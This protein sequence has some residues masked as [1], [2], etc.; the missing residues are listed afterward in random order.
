MR[1][2]YAA[3]IALLAATEANAHAFL[4]KSEPAVG[5]TVILPKSLRL[6]FT[7]AV[8]LDFSGLDVADAMGMPVA[9][10]PLRYDGGDH[11]GLMADLPPLPPG[12]YRVRW[13]VVSVDTHRT[14]GDFGFT[15]KP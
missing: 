9:T 10:G 8:E 6:Q 12:S 3:L 5:Q 15:V 1:K 14:E 2:L 11:K 13:H 7:E 4:M